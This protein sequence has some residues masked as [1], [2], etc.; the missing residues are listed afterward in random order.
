MQTPKNQ[1]EL[2]QLLQEQDKR[3]EEMRKAI[4]R[5]ESKLKMAVTL[6]ERV[7]GQN[8][9]LQEQTAILTTKLVEVNAR[10]GRG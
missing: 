2:L 6:S 4:I 1:K 9:R 3:I 7:Q 10:I 5:L 8:R